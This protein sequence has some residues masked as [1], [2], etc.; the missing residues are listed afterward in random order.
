MIDVVMTDTFTTMSSFFMYGHPL[1]NDKT[2]I[3]HQASVEASS[4]TK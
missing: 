3:N 1:L 2:V 4:D